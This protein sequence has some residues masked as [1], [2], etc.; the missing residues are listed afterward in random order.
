M[1][2]TELAELSD[3]S[4]MADLRFSSEEVMQIRQ[5]A[6]VARELRCQTGWCDD[7][8]SARTERICQE[9]ACKMPTFFEGRQ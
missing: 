4:L 7:H 8:C 3:A 5:A 1:T 6:F 9:I 2:P